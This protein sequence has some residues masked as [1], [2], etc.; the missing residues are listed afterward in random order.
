MRTIF[1]T[2]FIHSGQLFDSRFL[3][4]DIDYLSDNNAKSGVYAKMTPSEKRV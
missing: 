1:T 4:K 3:I 2:R